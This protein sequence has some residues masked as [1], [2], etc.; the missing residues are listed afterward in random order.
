MFR[1]DTEFDKSEYEYITLIC[2]CLIERWDLT[3]DYLDDK[4]IRFIFADK[5]QFE[6]FK[7]YA[8]SVT[9]SDSE[10]AL[11]F[12]VIVNKAK[13]IDDEIIID[14]DTGWD[15]RIVLAKILDK[16]NILLDKI[17]KKRKEER[18]RILQTEYRLLTS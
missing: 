6:E 7:R 2:Q 11:D 9:K 12:D 8:K 10:L 3:Y 4:T 18:L 15:I 16:R 13:Y 5:T 14:L 1:E 17:N